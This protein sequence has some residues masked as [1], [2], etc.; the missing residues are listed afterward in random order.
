[1]TQYV[2]SVHAE[3]EFEDSESQPTAT[4]QPMSQIELDPER[5]A[6]QL[7][8]VQ[9]VPP[10]ERGAEVMRVAELV[11]HSVSSWVD[12]YRLVF[13]VKGLVAILYPEVEDQQAFAQTREYGQLQ[14]Q[15]NALR[16]RD[17]G[18]AEEVEPQR[19]ITIRVPRSIHERLCEEADQLEVSVNKLCISKLIQHPDRQTVP[20]ERGKRRGRR[21]GPQKRVLKAEVKQQV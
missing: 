16:E 12:Y 17:T 2:E 18:K 19:M 5:V 3:V 7:P 8:E 6:P 20:K 4:S 10:G 1:M 14:E 11:F 13:G 9:Q 21:P 15:L